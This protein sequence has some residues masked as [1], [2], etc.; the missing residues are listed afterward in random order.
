LIN[1]DS[2]S[3]EKTV[4][5]SVTENLST[6]EG[7]EI[8]I[9][10][11]VVKFIIKY[12]FYRHHYLGIIFIVL[13]SVAIDLLLKNYSLFSNKKFIE[14]FLN[15]LSILSEMIY[16]CH[17]SYIIIR[18][19]LDNNKKIMLFLGITLLI[20]NTISLICILATPKESSL[21]FINNFWDYFDNNSK[22]IIIVD[23]IINLIL[24]FIFSLLEFLTIY[25]LRVY[26]ILIAHVLS[27]YFFILADEYD[28]TKYICILFFILQFFFL[29]IYLEILELNILHLNRNTLRTIIS[30]YKYDYIEEEERDDYKIKDLEDK[31]IIDFKVGIKDDKNDNEIAGSELV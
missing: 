31:Y 28:Y 24:Q 18:L 13:S 15:I 19:P 5:N 12:K 3:E 8:I 16:L 2:N 20:I 1:D 23:F 14:I 22:G 7:I 25:Y 26:F 17:I 29:M 30:G 27:K 11:I 21:S 10:T 9:I 4:L 6:K